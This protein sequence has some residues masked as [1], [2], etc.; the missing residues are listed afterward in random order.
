MQPTMLTVTDVTFTYPHAPEPLFQHVGTT[1]P[2]GWTAV[3][4]DNG[5]GK[6]TLMS[7]VRGELCPDSGTVTPNPRRLVIG[8]CPQ[9]IAVRPANLEDFAADWS[10]E[11][12]AVR[13][14]LQLGDDWP[15]AFAR[16]S[17]GERKRVQ[18]ACALT[19]RPDVLILDEPTNHVDADTRDRIIA[20]MR[21]YRGIGIVVSHDVDLI[22]AVCGRCV[23]FERRH[24]GSRNVTVLS[25]FRGGY[26]EAVAQIGMRD[27]A[28]AANADAL[29]REIARLTAAKAQRYA[30]VQQVES[31]KSH[32]EL[33]DR[34][35]HDALNRRKLAKMTGLDRGV[36]R[37]YGQID[38]RLAE[39]QRR[40]ESIS[41]PTKRYDGELWLD[42]VPS[43]CREVI[44]LGPGV[45]PFGA[46]STDAVVDA[47]EDV[48]K[49]TGG[50]AADAVASADG[51]TGTVCA[52]VADIA[53]KGAKVPV[54]VVDPMATVASSGEWSPGPLPLADG[55]I[56]ATAA[57]EIAADSAT[58]GMFAT[59]TV[60]AEISAGLS[61]VMYFGDR[62]RVMPPQG[63]SSAVGLRIP[64]ISIGPRDHI[65]VTGPNGTGKSALIR[66]MLAH[67]VDVPRLVIAQNTTDTDREDAMRRLDALPADVRA[68][69]L[70]AYARLDADP[71]K[72]RVTGHPSP[73]ELRK[74]LLCLALP[75]RPQLIVLDEPTNH[76]DLSSKKALASMLAGYPGALVVVSHDKWFLRLA[77]FGVSE[78]G[79]AV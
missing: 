67:T 39:A 22:D 75:A 25:T 32:G 46:N 77:G 4:G 74:L 44:R 78:E 35:D 26:S 54:S 55:M 8:Y 29:R 65:A 23:M 43:H 60:S 47:A 61:R 31:R 41:T 45:I 15:Y 52:N 33:I 63:G 19:L 48:P 37:A 42:V 36:T 57:G 6:S 10:P 64:L 30:K 49:A 56:A 3:L 18:I 1:F 79:P 68:Q 9:D 5:I 76:L 24:V 20:A 58:A 73:G 21:R 17:G 11:A 51:M 53:G 14:D 27:A 70:G 40:A 62:I 50:T 66:A 12:I 38:G 69:V 28:N 34:H 7:I 13:D 71:D 59:D 2:L 72:L 16:L